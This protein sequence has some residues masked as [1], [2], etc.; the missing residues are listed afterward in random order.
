MTD[1]LTLVRFAHL[2]HRDTEKD[3]EPQMTLIDTN[4]IRSNAGLMVGAL[5]L[6]YIQLLHAARASRV[7]T[8]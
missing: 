4:R 7:P 8:G 6:S 3:I 1:N 2:R 5:F